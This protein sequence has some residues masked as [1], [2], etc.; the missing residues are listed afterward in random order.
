VSWYFP[1]V[2]K[3]TTNSI[4]V[5]VLISGE[6]A[7]GTVLSNVVDLNYRDQLLR[8]MA[9]SRAWANVTARKPTIV[10]EKVADVAVAQPGGTITYTIFYNNTGSRSAAHV[11]IND[12]LPQ[13]VTF[14]SSSVAPTT[15]SG[16]TYGW[17]FTNVALGAHSLTITV[18]VNATAPSGIIT[19][20]AVL[21]Y[22][23]SN[24]KPLAG[25]SDSA[26]V[27]V[28]VPELGPEHFA[29]ALVVLLGLA[30]RTRRRREAI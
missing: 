28:V 6:P 8:P 12:T 14:Q 24:S 17:H 19:N 4:T 13:H 22:T 11:W 15:V 9:A 16:L 29:V 21:N 30:Y 26:S 3:E 25:S 18:Q 20:L 27:L 2:T 7:D 1:T 10:V 5:S 23:T